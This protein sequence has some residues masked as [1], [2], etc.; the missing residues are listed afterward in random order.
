MNPLRIFYGN[1]PAR[2]AV[3]DFLLATL[4][5]MAADL[6]V[7]GESTAGIKEAVVCVEKSFDKLQELYGTMPES[8]I[9][10]SR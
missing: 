6:A 3:Q 8:V 9:P 2:T 1:E 4:R 7:S 5:E 10:N